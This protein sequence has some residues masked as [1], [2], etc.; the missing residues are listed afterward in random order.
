MSAIEPNLLNP[1]KVTFA[2]KAPVAAQQYD[3]L[4]R[5]PINVVVKDA[6]FQVDAQ[7]KWNM[8]LDS[9][10]INS[11]GGVDEQER[12]YM[13]LR[14]K[15]LDALSKVL[16]RGD[17]ITKIDVKEVQFYVLRLEYGSHY[18]GKFRLVKLVFGD[19]KGQDG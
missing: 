15:D 5:T 12:G 16:A 18:A 1:T 3:H 13:I 9:P 2:Q 17:R 10:P 19:R 4:R 8:T 11:Q 6:T 7:I 14:T